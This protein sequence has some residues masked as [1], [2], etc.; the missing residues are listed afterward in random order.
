MKKPLYGGIATARHMT[1]TQTLLWAAG[2]MLGAFMMLLQHDCAVEG[3]E[4]N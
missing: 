3:S 2:S 1:T 4:G